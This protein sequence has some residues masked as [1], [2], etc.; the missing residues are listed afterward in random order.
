MVEARYAELDGLAPRIASVET[1]RATLYRHRSALLFE[2][3]FLAERQA[4]VARRLMV[5][6]MAITYAMGGPG[7][8]KGAF[9]RWASYSPEQRERIVGPDVARVQAMYELLRP[10]DDELATESRSSP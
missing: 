3:A 1:Y 8:A 10:R 6:S 2:L 9:D 7:P 5:T 4:T